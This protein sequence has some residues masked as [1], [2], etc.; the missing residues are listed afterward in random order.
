[1]RTIQALNK[2]EKLALPASKTALAVA[3]VYTLQVGA[4][5]AQQSE[6][7]DVEVVP[8]GTVEKKNIHASVLEQAAVE[9]DNRANAFNAYAKVVA[10]EAS[11][12]K[13]CSDKAPCLI[14]VLYTSADARKNYGQFMIEHGKKFD[15]IAVGFTELVKAADGRA[16]SLYSDY[17]F[18]R[19]EFFS[20]YDNA[21]NLLMANN[22][23]TEQ[24]AQNLLSN[25]Q[26]A[27]LVTL[28]IE[29]D[30]QAYDLLATKQLIE[31]AGVESQTYAANINAYKAYAI[32]AKIEGT[33]LDSE[34]YKQGRNADV[35]VAQ[36]NGKLIND[37]LNSFA[38]VMSDNA[39]K[40]TESAFLKD[41]TVSGFAG[42]QDDSEPTFGGGGLSLFFG[43]SKRIDNIR[44][45]TYSNKNTSDEG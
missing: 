37:N 35:L 13:A 8:I 12:V 16:K 45:F 26:Y 31:I 36:E 10:N 15:S 4:V 5:N 2:P 32:D 21:L 17:D 3:I 25:E 39:Y 9:M 11:A 19:T 1:M 29:L 14:S 41:V 38:S 43:N 27:A 34:G 33:K 30:T 40:T 22:V 24:D 44:D 23:M 6:M 20:S 42:S 28:S 18:K 7:V